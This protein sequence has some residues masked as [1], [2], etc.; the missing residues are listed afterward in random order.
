MATEVNGLGHA[1]NG[2]AAHERGMTE[3]QIS[4]RLLGKTPEQKIG[5]HQGKHPVAQELQTLIGDPARGGARMGQRLLQQRRAGEAMAK[6]LFQLAVPAPPPIL[7]P[8]QAVDTAAS[9]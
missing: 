8:V 1:E 4:F 5:H 6:R 3:G 7:V 9:Q 2:L